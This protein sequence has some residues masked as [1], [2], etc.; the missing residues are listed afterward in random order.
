ATIHPD[1][2]FMTTFVRDGKP[3]LQTGSVDQFVT[4]V[5]TP[6][7]QVW[8]ERI[9]DVEIEVDDRLAQARMDY[10]FYLGEELSHCGVNAFQLFDDGT[11]WKIIQ[12][13]DTRR[14][15]GCEMPD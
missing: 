6:H 9:W 3:V 14:Q 1:A 4:A 12:V 7:D 5:G 11:S 10:A 8:N 2:R 13:T 15:E